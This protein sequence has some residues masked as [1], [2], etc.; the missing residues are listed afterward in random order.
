MGWYT[1]PNY[2]KKGERPG[3]REGGG[4]RGFS[5]VSLQLCDEE[6]VLK[7][8]SVQQQENGSDQHLI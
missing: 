1:P 4:G 8:L 6:V 2:H 5:P 3:E 7:P